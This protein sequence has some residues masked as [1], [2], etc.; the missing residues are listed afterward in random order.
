[1]N[2]NF[3]VGDLLKVLSHGARAGVNTDFANRQAGYEHQF[4][5]NDL[6]RSNE[7]RDYRRGRDAIAD[8]RYNRGVNWDRFKYTHEGAAKAMKPAK[9][10]NSVEALMAGRLAAGE[11]TEDDYLDY[12]RRL[13]ESTRKPSGG[14]PP[15][16][17]GKHRTM[18]GT[19]RKSWQTDPANLTGEFTTNATGKTIGEV[20]PFPEQDKSRELYDRNIWPQAA[21]YGLNS[22]S[23]KTLIGL[24]TGG[25]ESFDNAQL[26][27]V[28]RPQGRQLDPGAGQPQMSAADQ[29][30]VDDILAYRKAKPG[31]K[32]NWTKLQ[33][34]NPHLN[35]E[36]IMSALK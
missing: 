19:E 17:A 27:T 12:R 8:D 22:D 7:E 16:F 9:A 11:I 25:G 21:Q 20:A 10:P 6:L 24:A 3:N 28:M 31:S 32:T 35:W 34:D 30:A 33:Q 23:L 36:A 2:R 5:V 26:N 1:M 18:M 14:K 15:D 13:S 4:D 29:E